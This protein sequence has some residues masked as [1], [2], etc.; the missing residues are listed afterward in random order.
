MK[1]PKTP[2]SDLRQR[3][4]QTVR[5]RR[6]ITGNSRTVHELEV[7]EVELELQ[8]EELRTA[9]GAL[10]VA[11]DRYRE[12]FDFAPLGYAVL[13]SAGDIREINH[14]GAELLRVERR[15]VINQRFAA[16]V[17]TTSLRAVEDVF[18][19]ALSDQLKVTAE[20]ELCREGAT[21]PIR[22][23]ACAL[24]REDATL[25]V[26][27]EDIS[28]RK[29]KETALAQSE[30]ALRESNLRKDDFL[31]TLSHEIRNPLTPICASI[32]LLHLAPPGSDDAATALSILD[33]SAK[34]MSRL[35]ED[36]LDVTRIAH[37][38]I[39]LRREVVDLP[40]LLQRVLQDHALALEER[41]LA[42]DLPSTPHAV[43]GDPARLV[44][45][46]SNIVGN[47]AKFTRPG[48]RIDVSLHQSGATLVVR[49]SDGGVGIAPEMIDHVFEPFMQA[50]QSLARSSGGLGLGLAMVKSFVDMHGGSVAI[51]SAGVG[52][53][54]TVTV[55]LPEAPETTRVAPPLASEPARSRRIL[56][57]EDNALAA[58]VLR[59][60]LVRQGHNVEVAHRANSAL[61]LSRAFEPEIVLCDIGLPDIDGYTLAP[62]LLEAS[63]G[64]QKPLLVAMTGYA[65]PEDVA[66]AKAA[67]FDFHLAK[68]VSFADLE[69]ILA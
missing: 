46:F 65:R 48:D 41:K 49:V 21:F 6:A 15:R 54:T 25:L 3:A 17:A 38:K 35:V 50:P 23:V 60:I 4:E 31:A 5:K 20:V 37:G 63:H 45:V 53:G 14:A 51:Q 69:R 55:T 43:F 62:M 8:N 27:F 57:V 44:Q 12:V 13:T 67:G 2:G 9:R 1:R 52:L 28:E 26:S 42:V 61:E 30:D 10:E 11:L 58:L 29:A 34:Q 22:L 16:F 19:R 33:R 32:A 68:P 18:K 64:H 36:L 47:A 66:A 39:E 7:H 59:K 40:A 56:V 24:R